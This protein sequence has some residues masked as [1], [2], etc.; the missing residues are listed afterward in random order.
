MKHA[1]LKHRDSIILRVNNLEHSLHFYTSSFGCSI[2]SLARDSRMVRLELGVQSIVLIDIHSALGRRVGPTTKEH[3][4]NV[5]RFSLDVDP[6]EMPRLITRLSSLWSPSENPA[7]KYPNDDGGW[8]ICC[9]DPDG[10]Q[11]D[12][13]GKNRWI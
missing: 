13:F 4:S 7:M 3:T 6:S 11:I 1:D 2:A 8:A 10:N 12:L 9:F 5:S